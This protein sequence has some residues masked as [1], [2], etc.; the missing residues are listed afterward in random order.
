MNWFI[1]VTNENRKILETDHLWEAVGQDILNRVCTTGTGKV[2]LLW[3]YEK[4]SLRNDFNCK[5][6]IH[7]S[8]F[9]FWP[10]MK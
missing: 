6:Q 2:Y 10:D 9:P 5:I 4:I 7:Y 8:Q 1:I 3:E